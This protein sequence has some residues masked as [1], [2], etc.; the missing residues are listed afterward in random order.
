MSEP[1][2][3]SSLQIKDT[4][5]GGNASV[6]FPG[7]GT[8]K[9]PIKDGKVTGTKSGTFSQGADGVAKVTWTVTL[10]V[11]SYATDVSFTD[12]LGDN[13]DFVNDSFKL[14]GKKLDSQ[15]MTDGQVDNLDSL[16]TFPGATT[17][18]RTIRC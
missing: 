12:T 9:I 18:S 1:I 7:V 17:R 2:C 10:T 14:D 8:I 4:S 11:E 13:F 16:A 6:V 15:P 3:R 5:S